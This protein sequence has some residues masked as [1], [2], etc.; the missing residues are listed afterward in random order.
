MTRP[1]ADWF[2]AAGH[3]VAAPL[4]TVLATAIP[5]VGRLD[6]KRVAAQS[7][8]YTPEMLDALAAATATGGEATGA[9]AGGTGGKKGGKRRKA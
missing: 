9:D 3:L 2:D 5:A 4:Q 1:F 6:A 8:A 7:P